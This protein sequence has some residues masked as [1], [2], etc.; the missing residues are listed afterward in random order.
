M[1]DRTKALEAFKKGDL[2]VYAVYTSSIWMKQTDFD[3]VQK[4]WAVKQQIFNREPIGFQ[5]MAMNL[6][7]DKF[8]DV[9]VRK[10][11]SYLMNRQ[12]MNEKYMYNQYFLLNSYYLSSYYEYFFC[13]FVLF[14]NIRDNFPSVM[15][16]MIEKG[17]RDNKKK[18]MNKVRKEVNSIVF[19][20]SRSLEKSST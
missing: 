19:W 7:R 10:A 2:D 13:S 15:I 17:L 11:L 8:K 16:W 1:E 5:G 18:L 14:L 12:L 4:G 9:R 3:A 20:W 6:R